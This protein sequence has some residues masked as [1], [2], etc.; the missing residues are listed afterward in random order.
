MNIFI[1][2]GTGFLGYHAALEARRRGHTVTALGLPPIPSD[3][4]FTANTRLL[5]Q[6]LE[7]TSDDDLRTLMT[8]HSALIFAAGLDDR[9]TPLKPAYPAFRRANV[10]GTRRILILA[11]E[12]GIRRV[13][14]LGSYFAY[15]ARQLPHLHLAD[16]H[17]YIRSRVEQEQV[18][19]VLSSPDFEVMVLEL[20]YIF[21]SMP[22]RKPLWTPLVR[23]IAR[24]NPVLY[25]RGGSACI[26]VGAVAGAILGALEQGRGGSFYPIGDE[27][28][29]WSELLTRLASTLGKR[30]KVLTL[31][32]WTVTVAGWGIWL[33]RTLQGR[34]AGLDM[35][36]FAPLQTSELFIDPAPARTALGFRTGDLD[37]ALRETVR[38][39]IGGE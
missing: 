9:F 2:G 28:L 8:G 11:R 5:L 34:E 10:E 36:Y 23:Y 6:D 26:S 17:P 19:L 3:E 22:G 33:A 38:A 27:N 4:D 25:M 31:P 13:V 16:H 15:A 24:A 7:H 21:G 32:A 30:I 12:A 14:V 37:D 29:R 1:V 18:C 35:R 20:P 39:A